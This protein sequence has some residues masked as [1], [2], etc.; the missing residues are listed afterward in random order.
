MLFWH[1][2]ARSLMSAYSRRHAVLGGAPHL[3]CAF[4]LVMTLVGCSSEPDLPPATI[5]TTSNAPLYKIG[6]GDVLSIFVWGH[7]DLASTVNVRPDGHISAPLIIDLR[8]A[9]KTPSELASDINQ[10]L[11]QYIIE[12]LT[13][14]TVSEFAGTNAQQVRVVGEAASPQAIPY[15]ADM[16]LLDVMIVVGGLT[17]FASGNRATIVRIVDDN[18]QEFGARLDDLLRD[19]DITAN[20]AM[21]PGDV[22]IIPKT[23]F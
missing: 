8:A 16:T 9:G 21:R 20:V 23:F 3:A 10:E 4:L 19:G 5:N 15:R 6:P 18:Q 12:P 1:K 2:S 17:E 22:L 13:T 11:D 14:V 7:P